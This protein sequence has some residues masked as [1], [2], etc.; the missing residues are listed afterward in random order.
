MQPALCGQGRR[1][2]SEIARRYIA[3]HETT[4]TLEDF[5]K[6]AARILKDRGHFFMVH[7]PSRL[8]DIFC[9]CRSEGLEPK[10]VRF[11]CPKKGAA[12]NIVLIHCVAGGGK[13]LT[14][15]K[16]LVVYGENGAYTPEIERYTK[17]GMSDDEAYIYRSQYG[18][19]RSRQG[20]R[21]GRASFF[22]R[23]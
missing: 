15:M 1:T 18:R 7:R 20:R 10:N 9:A 13:E 6:A 2:Y 23:R 21:Q 12:P 11:V 19:L 8:V 5:V 17:E 4:A 16:E 14:V 3:R 22:L